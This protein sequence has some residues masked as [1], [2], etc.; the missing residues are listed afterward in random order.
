MRTEENRFAHLEDAL[1]GRTFKDQKD[2]PKYRK[3]RNDMTPQYLK[4][5]R[6]A[7]HIHIRETQHI[8]VDEGDHCP[9]CRKVTDFEHGHLYCRFCDWDNTGVVTVEE[10]FSEVA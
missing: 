9:R 5:K 8:D 1:M 6:E 2:Y 7:P 4:F 10:L 3:A